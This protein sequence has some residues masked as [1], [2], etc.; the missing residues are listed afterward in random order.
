MQ[1]HSFKIQGMHCAACRLIIEDIIGEDKETIKAEVSLKTNLLHVEGDFSREQKD[2]LEDWQGQLKV[3]GYSLHSQEEG[4]EGREREEGRGE[5]GRGEEGSKIEENITVEARK[6]KQTTLLQAF[7]LGC[8][9]LFG[10]VIFQ[11]SGILDFSTGESFNLSTAFLL[12]LIASL[13]SCLA[14]V[15][16]LVLSLS[17]NAAKVGAKKQSAFMFHIGRLLSFIVLGA[18]LGL[19]GEAFSVSH[20]VT[21][22]LGMLAALVMIIVGLNLLEVFKGSGHHRFMTLPDKIFR[23]ITKRSSGSFSPFIVGAGTFFLPCGFTQSMQILALASSSPLQGALIMGL[24]A[25]GT[26]PVLSTLSF[27]SFSLASSKYG[28]LFFKTSGI[29][30]VGLG[31]YALLGILAVF[32]IIKPLTLF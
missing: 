8:F 7:L 29:V 32:G 30:V 19:V 13:S 6:R 17:A 11:R 12:G 15:G 3:H 25:L 18:L 26:L 24:F 20:E 21:S 4:E 23:S 9:I 27:A 31:L 22:F 28:S 2:L 16:G 5:E 14:V 10:F 1:K